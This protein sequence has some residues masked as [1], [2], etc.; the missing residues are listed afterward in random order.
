VTAPQPIQ[1]QTVR[2][3]KGQLFAASGVFQVSRIDGTQVMDRGFRSA[4]PGCVFVVLGLACSAVTLVFL[5][6]GLSVA[7]AEPGTTEWFGQVAAA[8]MFVGPCLVMAIVF[9]VIHVRAQP[10]TSYWHELEIWIS[11]ARHVIAA[12]HTDPLWAIQREI[13][14]AQRDLEYVGP[15]IYIGHVNQVSGNNN[16][17]NFDGHGNSAQTGGGAEM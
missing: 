3:E 14:A 13:A 16:A 9:F 6:A 8:S 11:G 4:G 5:L 17:V 10:K 15:P 1:Q 7:T 2:V 12:S